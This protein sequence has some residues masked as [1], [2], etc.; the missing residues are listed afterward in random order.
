MMMNGKTAEQA[1][2]SGNYSIIKIQYQ[3]GNSCMDFEADR[4][5]LVFRTLP[6][7]VT[8]AISVQLSI[9]SQLVDVFIAPV[10]IKH[11]FYY[12]GSAVNRTTINGERYDFNSYL[13]TTSRS[14]TIY[15]FYIV[16]FN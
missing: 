4:V 8:D 13:Y 3:L 7:S 14:S 10:S 1:I 16:N 11:Y 9:D 5:W 12:S 15:N 2:A 6:S